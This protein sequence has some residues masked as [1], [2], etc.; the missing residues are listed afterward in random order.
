MTHQ[1]V[2]ILNIKQT[3]IIGEKWAV[4]TIPAH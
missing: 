2:F 4:D 3:E 1:N